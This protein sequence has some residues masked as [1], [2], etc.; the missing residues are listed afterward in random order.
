MGIGAETAPQTTD[1]PTFSD[2]LSKVGLFLPFYPFSSISRL[3]ST[4]AVS[5]VDFFTIT[6]Y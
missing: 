5:F 1:K 2:F 6:P 4:Q 3:I